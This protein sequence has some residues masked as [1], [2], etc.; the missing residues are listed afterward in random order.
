MIETPVKLL[1]I[2]ID[3]TDTWQNGPLYEAIVRLLEQRGIA[4]ATVLSGI[5]GY[6]AHRRIHQKGL[7][8][9]S[10]DKPITIAVVDNEEKLRAV[11]PEIRPMIREGLV[12]LLSDFEVIQ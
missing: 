2:F 4:G 7:L 1:L 11:L 10:D 8:G 5:M 6:G 12:G 3:R 9:V